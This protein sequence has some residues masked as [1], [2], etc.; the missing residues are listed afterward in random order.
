MSRRV[1]WAILALYLA[2]LV[3]ATLAPL[4]DSYSQQ[5]GLDKWAHAALFFG[6]AFLAYWNLQGN[7]RVTLAALSAMA[8]AAM[9][10]ILQIPLPYRS[11]DVWDFA[12]GTAGAV[13][14]ALLAFLLVGRRGGLLGG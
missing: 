8:A 2:G 4:P 11:G 5:S 12:A 1:R 7:P 13:M 9:I 3:G 10:E 6:L 14:G